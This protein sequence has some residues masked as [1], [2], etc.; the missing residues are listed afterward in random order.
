MSGV[1]S[2]VGARL[3]FVLARIVGGV[4]RERRVAARAR[5]AVRGAS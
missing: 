2:S 4:S 3:R 1:A 5:V